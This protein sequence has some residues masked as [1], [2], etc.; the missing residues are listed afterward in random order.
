M[1]LGWMWRTVVLEMF[2]VVMD[3]CSSL[4]L[5]C[6]DSRSSDRFHLQATENLISGIATSHSFGSAQRTR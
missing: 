1:G 2:E 3:G 5:P 6:Q 4:Q